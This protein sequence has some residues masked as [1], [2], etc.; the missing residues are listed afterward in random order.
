M[1]DWEQ[2][3]KGHASLVWTTA[4]RLLNHREDASDCT[5]EAFLAALAVARR[6]RVRNWKSL[7]V[8]L[9]TCRAL[10]HLRRRARDEAR[11]ER[12]VDCGDLLSPAASPQQW[13]E[14]AELAD[15]LR[16]ALARLPPEQAEV[17]C[18]R[19]FNELSYRDISRQ[20]GIPPSTVSVLLYRARLRLR[21]LLAQSPEKSVRP[22]DATPKTP[23]EQ[24]R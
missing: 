6:E 10:D 3:V 17:F 23:P 1:T 7:L 12:S 20:T 13:G 21:E 5:Q 24:Q 22:C 11:H 9:C 19:F 14:K 8:R 15:A 16:Q 2:I 18:L 4:F